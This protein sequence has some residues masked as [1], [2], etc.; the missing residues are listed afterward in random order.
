ML[1]NSGEESNFVSPWRY[2]DKNTIC[3][4]AGETSTAS[5]CV[6]CDS[7]LILCMSLVVF[8]SVVVFFGL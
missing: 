5:F 3:L 1:F 2:H 8:D 4:D 7:E 6:L